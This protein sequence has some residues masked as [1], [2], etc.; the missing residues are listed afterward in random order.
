[1]ASIM[2]LH[3]S[4]QEEDILEHSNIKCHL[5]NIGTHLITKGNLLMPKYSNRN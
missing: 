1:M 2:C 4:M 5:C 3:S